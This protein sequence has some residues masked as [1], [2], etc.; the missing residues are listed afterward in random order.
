MQAI[1]QLSRMLKLEHIGGCDCMNGDVCGAWIPRFLRGEDV[2]VAQRRQGRAVKFDGRQGG[3][4]EAAVSGRMRVVAPTRRRFPCMQA[5]LV[6]VAVV[7]A[8]LA[9]KVHFWLAALRR[10]HRAGK[11][12]RG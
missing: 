11:E 12:A 2:P 5:G 9:I 4:F 6:V 10:E 3:C 1:K 7:V 8:V